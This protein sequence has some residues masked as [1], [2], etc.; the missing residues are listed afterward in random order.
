MNIAYDRTEAKFNNLA[1]I[2]LLSYYSLS[3]IM[4]AVAQYISAYLYMLTVVLLYAVI[5]LKNYNTLNTYVM[6]LLPMLFLMLLQLLDIYYNRKGSIPL[7]MYSKLLY[8]IPMLLM[9]YMLYNNKRSLIKIIVVVALL[10]YIITALTTYLGLLKYPDA[11]RI[12]ATIENSKD[13]SAV[14]FGSLNIGGF[15]T[16][17]SIV[18]LFPLIICLFKNRK[19]PLIIF[20]VITALILLCIIQS[21]YA[22][23]FIL[24][25]SST[26][27]IFAGKE[28][29]GNKVWYLIVI[30][31]LLLFIFKSQVAFLLTYLANNVQS[32]TLRER[33]LF[34][35][36]SL[37]GIENESDVGNRIDLYMMSINSFL[38]YPLS[39]AYLFSRSS[40]G[41]HSFILDT[42][43]QFGMIGGA[44]LF[45]FF[46]QI[47]IKLY[48]PFK[49]KQYFG[50]MIW[51]FILYIVLSILN[52]TGFLIVLGLLVPGIAYILQDGK[53]RTSPKGVPYLEDNVGD[54]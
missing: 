11:A 8:Y 52:P 37:K 51:S 3:T 21:Q 50:Y 53:Y 7:F 14:K 39:G 31:A 44:A 17:Y 25:V 28:L 19:I 6:F 12:L 38:K 45:T 54:Q 43:G 20:I 9:F 5:I 48:L 10:A 22:T 13:I 32:S 42:L 1:M 23:A 34:L 40:T 47:Y 26:V 18:I 33:F 24:F 2:L 15:E 41:G 29:K 16:I 46:R 27:L 35:A 36:N 4:P 49:E 30:T